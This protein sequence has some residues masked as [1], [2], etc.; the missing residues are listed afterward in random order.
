ML[1]LSHYGWLNCSMKPD[2]SFQR[3]TLLESNVNFLL[4]FSGHSM[5]DLCKFYS[6][7]FPF[8]SAEWI[9]RNVFLLQKDCHTDAKNLFV[10]LQ[11]Q[12]P[13]TNSE[14]LSVNFD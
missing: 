4:L 7:V 9:T 12:C 10:P 5:N 3:K 8:S 6:D 14:Q 13:D 1:L 2:N 11:L